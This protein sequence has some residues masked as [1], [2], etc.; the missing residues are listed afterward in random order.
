VAVGAAQPGLGGLVDLDNVRVGQD[1]ID[2]S[3]PHHAHHVAV[4]R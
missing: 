1:F 2:R 3:W 4:M